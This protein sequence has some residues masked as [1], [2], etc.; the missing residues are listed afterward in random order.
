M[1]TQGPGVVG[2]YIYIHIYSVWSQA[3]A[4]GGLGCRTYGSWLRV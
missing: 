2:L 4:V 3:F 1:L